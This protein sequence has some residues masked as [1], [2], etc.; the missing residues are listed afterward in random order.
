MTGLESI[1]IPKNVS[2]LDAW[3]FANCPK[4]EE[5]TVDPENTKYTSRD[6]NENECNCI[7]ANVN[8]GNEI[9]KTL[10]VGCKTTI[11]PTDPE[12]TAIGEGAFNNQSEMTSLTIPN[13]IVVISDNEV[14]NG[15]SALEDIYYEGTIAQFN[16]IKTGP[17]AGAIA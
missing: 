6:A 10:L 13:N 11:I 3:C 12:L 17:G 16:Q 9:I 5:I 4:L 8:N 14:L 15:C 1:N 7:I 2:Q